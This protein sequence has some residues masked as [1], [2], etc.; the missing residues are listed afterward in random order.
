MAGGSGIIRI[1]IKPVWAKL[2]QVKPQGSAEK[3]GYIAILDNV[4]A[5]DDM[6]MAESNC[7]HMIAKTIEETE[8]KPE[9]E[10][11]DGLAKQDA[12]YH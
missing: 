8:S 3:N 12:N 11:Q 1:W 6:K 7:I 10:L 4:V 2:S 9:A 5:I